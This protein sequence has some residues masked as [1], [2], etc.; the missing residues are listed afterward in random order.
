MFH[1]IMMVVSM[2]IGCAHLSNKLSAGANAE[3]WR[4]KSAQVDAASKY[5]GMS[6]WLNEE[7]ASA[8]AKRG[9]LDT[10][11]G[12]PLVIRVT[13]AVFEKAD[14]S[15]VAPLFPKAL[16]PT[17]IDQVQPMY[18]GAVTVELVAGDGRRATTTKDTFVHDTKVIKGKVREEGLADR[19]MRDLVRSAVIAG[20]KE[21]EATSVAE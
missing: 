18:W 11:Q 4:I 1:V 14:R 17:N 9:D 3:T 13:E 7:V 15:K 2:Q 10:E 19:T 8:L 5:V 12:S 20:L 16:L 6:A 21:I